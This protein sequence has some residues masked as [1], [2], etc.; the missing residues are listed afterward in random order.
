M[1]QGLIRLRMETGLDVHWVVVPPASA[2]VDPEPEL[3]AKHAARDAALLAR[4]YEF[5]FPEP[6]ELPAP[7][8]ARRASAML[9]VDRP[10][11]EQLVAAVRIGNALWS[12]DGNALA[13]A[14]H[15]LGA[16]AG[17]DVRPKLEE[18][19]AA[20]RR[21]GHFA[22]SVVRYGGAWYAGVARLSRL[23]DHVAS[24]VGR[25]VSIDVLRPRP[26]TDRPEAHDV[27]VVNGR[28]PLDVF[29]SY[30]SPYSYIALPQLR[31]LVEELPIDL[32]LRPL[33][34]MAMRGL[35]VPQA[36]RVFI[37][38]DAKLEAERLGIPFG[39]V[40]DPIGDGAERCLAAHILV[41]EPAGKALDFAESAMR[42]I[43]AEAID[44]ATNEGLTLV[45][46]RAGLD[47]EE[48]IAASTD[49]RWR[50]VVEANREELLELGLWGVPCF[51]LG[52]LAT[53]GQDRIPLIEDRIRRRLGLRPADLHVARAS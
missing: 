26:A 27:P 28:V 2:D 7:D 37:A 23:A 11:E 42:G 31:R 35:Q 1:A 10:I 18:S 24:D 44:V 8:R 45:A 36:K 20:L 51:H 3:R 12:G 50:E 16:V 5:D 48:A 32:R 22:G 47:P 43:F 29:V 39:R 17:Q 38:R 53:W 21:D 9:L 13:D 30:R 52:E 19:Y 34:P 14:V 41:A 25:D 33:L 15:D 40:C 49:V 6:W 46:E 4:Y